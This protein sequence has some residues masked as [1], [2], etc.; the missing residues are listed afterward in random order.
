[1]EIILFCVSVAFILVLR[2]IRST[3]VKI[4]YTLE[5]ISN[6][7]EQLVSKGKQNMELH[8]MPQQD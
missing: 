3:L 6:Q 2:S 5:K 8:N 4:S 1:M 7:Q